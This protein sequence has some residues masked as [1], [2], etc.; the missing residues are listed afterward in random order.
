MSCFRFL[1]PFSSQW[2]HAFYMEEARWHKKVCVCVFV[3][4]KGPERS[5]YDVYTPMQVNSA[6]SQSGG[7]WCNVTCIQY[8]AH[9][10]VISCQILDEFGASC[11]WKDLPLAAAYGA[12]MQH[13]EVIITSITECWGFRLNIPRLEISKLGADT[14]WNSKPL[15]GY[16]TQTRLAGKWIIFEM[17]FLWKNDA[18]D[19]IICIVVFVCW[20]VGSWWAPHS[21]GSLFNLNYTSRI[22][23]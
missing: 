12:Q 6:Y 19:W 18:F 14:K 21:S 11:S 23:C 20:S 9:H 8:N 10:P 1:Q 5:T 13:H 2:W 16:N 17:H 22:C 3:T 4:N 7:M 15:L